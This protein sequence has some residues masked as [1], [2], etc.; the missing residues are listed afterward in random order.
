MYCGIDCGINGAICFIADNKIEVFDM[1]IIRVRQKNKVKTVLD[2]KKIINIFKERSAKL[3]YTLIEEVQS[4]PGQGSV[5]GVT[6]GINFGILIGILESLNINYSVIHPKKWQKFFN[7]YGNSAIVDR[8]ARKNDIKLQGK[9]IVTKLYPEI[10]FET[11][12]GRF[13]DGRSDAALIATYC[14]NNF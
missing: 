8:T 12:R 10:V 13:L 7:I 3:K 9:K 4:M 11:K 1:P 2:A 14:K 5:S 6:I